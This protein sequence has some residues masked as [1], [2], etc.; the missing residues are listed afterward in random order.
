MISDR[1]PLESYPAAIDQFKR[2][3]GRKIQVYV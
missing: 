2:G 1:L 3:I